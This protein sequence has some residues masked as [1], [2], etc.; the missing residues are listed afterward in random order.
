MTHDTPAP[1]C[2]SF[3]DE[4]LAAW[5]GNQPDKLLAFYTESAFYRDPAKPNGLKGHSEL[6]P[7][8]TRLLA[9]NPDW[10]WKALEILPTEIGFV[11]K[12]EATIPVGGR[13]IVETGLD[14]VELKDGRISRNE[15]YFNPSRL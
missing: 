8:F 10:A 9:K 12:W 11:L 6:L 15:V 4:W 5:T 3:C 13:V 14:I 2:A 1:F 7:Y